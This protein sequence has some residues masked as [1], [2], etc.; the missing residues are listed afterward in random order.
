MDDVPLALEIVL[1]RT[2]R[3]AKARATIGAVGADCTRAVRRA[4]FSDLG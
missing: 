4:E 1:R 3:L 2:R